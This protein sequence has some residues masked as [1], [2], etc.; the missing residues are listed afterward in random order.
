MINSF[1]IYE[2]PVSSLPSVTVVQSYFVHW[3]GIESPV[4]RDRSRASDSGSNITAVDEWNSDS[5]LQE[6]EVTP[7]PGTRLRL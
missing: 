3:A 4:V 5:L 1:H 6:D 7:L 2:I